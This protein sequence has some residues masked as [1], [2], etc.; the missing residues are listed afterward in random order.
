MTLPSSTGFLLLAL[1][2]SGCAPKKD[3]AA[4]PPPAEIA[5]RAP[6]KAQVEA[7]AKATETNEGGGLVFSPD[8]LRMCPGI[9]SPKFSFDSS[10][11]RAGWADALWTLGSCMQTGGLKNSRLQLTGYTDPRGEDDYNM[12]LGSRRTEAVKEA[13]HTFG[14]DSDRLFT[15]SRG[16]SEARGTDEETW[17]QDRRVDISLR[18]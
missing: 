10:E 6:S 8:I 4:P 7:V 15:T 3:P 13:L 5:Y 18:P 17:A 16:E 11:L 1:V 9:R 2:C 12:A 14:V